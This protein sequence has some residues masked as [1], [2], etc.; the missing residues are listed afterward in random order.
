MKRYHV[1]LALIAGIALSTNVD[2]AQTYRTE[3][4]QVQQL[5]QYDQS[6]KYEQDRRVEERR[7]AADR[8]HDAYKKQRR[9]LSDVC[10]QMYGDQMNR[11]TEEIYKN[12]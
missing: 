11:A 8:Y 5:P 4:Q 12:N 1:T 3:Q 7:Q 2:A 6:W 10:R 9:C